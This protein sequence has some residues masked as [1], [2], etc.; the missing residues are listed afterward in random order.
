ML[1]ATASD[2][3]YLDSGHVLDFTN[4]AFEALDIVGW[5][6]A[7][8]VFT[9]LVPLYTKA[10]RMEERSSWRHPVDLIQILD[11]IFQRNSHLIGNGPRKARNMEGL[12]SHY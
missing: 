7:E 12:K 3:R 9:S 8:G 6:M 11:K 4:K 10:T 5:D 2:H 1:F